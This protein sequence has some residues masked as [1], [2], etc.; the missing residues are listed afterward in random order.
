[1]FSYM[2]KFMHTCFPPVYTHTH[3]HT[4]THTNTHTKHVHTS[5]QLLRTL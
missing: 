2:Q 4:H 5:E 3:T 1:M